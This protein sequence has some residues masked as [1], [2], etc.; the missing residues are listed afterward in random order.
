MEGR[1]CQ[2]DRP[3]GLPVTGTGFILPAVIWALFFAAVYSIQGAGCAA[4]VEP[5]GRQGFGPLW[6][7]LLLLTLVAAGAI[8][9]SG[10]FSYRAWRQLRPAADRGTAFERAM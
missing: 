2:H 6:L 3:R 7:V 9:I 8:A 1:T 10:F 5:P 4:A